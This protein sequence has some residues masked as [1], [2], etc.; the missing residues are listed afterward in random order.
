MASVAAF[1][2]CCYNTDPAEPGMVCLGNTGWS[3]SADHCLVDLILRKHAHLTE[4]EEER[5]SLYGTGMFRYIGLFVMP[6]F[7]YL[8][9][10]AMEGWQG[11]PNAEASQASGVNTEQTMSTDTGSKTGHR[12]RLAYRYGKRCSFGYRY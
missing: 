10:A 6:F 11:I 5:Q 3:D 8:G 1:D 2:F 9:A 12:C 4:K 7:I